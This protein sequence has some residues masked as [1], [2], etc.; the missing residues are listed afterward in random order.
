MISFIH[1]VFYNFTEKRCF[2]IRSCGSERACAREREAGERER[3]RVCVWEAGE[4]ERD[5]VCVGSRRERPRVCVGSRR[6]RRESVREI[7]CVCVCER[8]AC[9][10]LGPV[11]GNR[12]S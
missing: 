1:C 11:K 3:V 9:V 8:N 7:A 10:E 6:E 5:R 12:C 2:E 4:R